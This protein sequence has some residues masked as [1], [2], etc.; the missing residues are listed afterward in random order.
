MSNESALI[1]MQIIPGDNVFLYS[2]FWHF[3]KPDFL[4]H[5]LSSTIALN[6]FHST[7]FFVENSSK[8]IVPVKLHVQPCSKCYICHIRMHIHL[9]KDKLS[10]AIGLVSSV[11]K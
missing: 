4:F 9:Y 2:S 11:Y 5:Y 10:E 7:V 8:K 3:A 1:F 6:W